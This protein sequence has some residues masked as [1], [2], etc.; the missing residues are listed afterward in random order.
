MKKIIFLLGI[1]L[2]ISSVSATDIPISSECGYSYISWNWTI[3]KPVSIYVDGHLVAENTSINN[4]I[5]SDL[6]TEERHHIVIVSNDTLD[7]GEKTDY[8]TYKGLKIETYFLIGC[9]LFFILLGMYRE[10][11]DAGFELFTG[12]GGGFLFTAH[13]IRNI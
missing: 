6:P 13:R 10:G 9:W 4:Y 3:E 2:L 1:L 11:R 5:I 7:I 8:T 12:S